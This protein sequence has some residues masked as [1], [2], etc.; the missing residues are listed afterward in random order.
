MSFEIERNVF[1]KFLAYDRSI[2]VKNFHAIAQAG[3][4]NF[5]YTGISYAGNQP[6]IVWFHFE[7]DIETVNLP[8]IESALDIILNSFVSQSLTELKLETMEKINE[9][10]DSWMN[11][12][13]PYAGHVWD[14]DSAGMTNI[15]GT[16][17]SAVL[18]QNAGLGLPADF[19]FRDKANNN[20]P[21]D[22]PFMAGLGLALFKFRG[23][24]YKASWIHKY[25][26]A[27]CTTE[28]EVLAYDWNVG[29][30]DRGA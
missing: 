24:C 10:R 21:A 17:L 16:N 26:V 4:H 11:S 19:V 7:G 5:G 14:C 12:W 1:G 15:Q 18:L 23:D 2:D 30:P 13:F 8:E 20:V 9:K 27:I 29:W 28:A 3:L 25:M 6:D 22:I